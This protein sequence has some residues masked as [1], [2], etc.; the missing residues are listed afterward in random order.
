MISLVIHCSCSYS[1][2]FDPSDLTGSV[3]A[4]DIGFGGTKAAVELLV[5]SSAGTPFAVIGL[6]VAWVGGEGS[7]FVL[8]VVEGVLEGVGLLGSENLKNVSCSLEL[9]V[10]IDNCYF[11][12]IFLT[13]ATQNKLQ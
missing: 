3:V 8:S 4:F 5:S 11:F 1:S 2:F 6:V 12:D 13:F 9:G 10:C 7:D